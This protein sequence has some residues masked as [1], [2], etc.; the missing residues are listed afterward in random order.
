MVRLMAVNSVADY[1]RVNAVDGA[2]VVTDAHNAVG[3]IRLYISKTFGTKRLLTCPRAAIH[4]DDVVRRMM[5][6]KR[7]REVLRRE[8]VKMI[9]YGK[10]SGLGVKVVDRS[11]GVAASGE[12]ETSVLDLL[13]KLNRLSGVV[14]KYYRSSVVKDR[15]D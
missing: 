4:V 13:K 10:N 15:T 7:P 9:A 2:L 14:W 1:L 3:E 6:L 11:S 8:E 12:T 5:T